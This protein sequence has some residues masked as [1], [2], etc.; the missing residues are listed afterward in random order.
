[1]DNN[2]N[3]LNRNRK[4][5]KKIRDLVKI[6]QLGGESKPATTTVIISQLFDREHKNVVQ[7]V[8]NLI[9][10]SGLTELNFKLSEYTDSTGRKLK[11]YILD[12]TFTS[13]LLMGFT[14]KKAIKWKL[15]Y[16]EEF[17]RMR[18]Q[19]YKESRVVRTAFDDPAE[20]NK[21]AN[22]VLLHTRTALGKETKTHHYMALAENVNE[23]AF[24]DRGKGKSLRKNMNLEEY[25]KLNRILSGTIKSLLKGHIHKQEIQEELD[26]A[27]LLRGKDSFMLIN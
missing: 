17:Q 15:A 7:A 13:L 8:Q 14:G 21:A 18:K 12:E 11:M 24:G 19:Q 23:F 3:I 2:P 22:D 6:S 20:L 16:I 9:K 5:I 27:K 1:M 25:Q 10:D 26:K 4:S